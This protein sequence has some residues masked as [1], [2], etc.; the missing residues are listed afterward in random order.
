MAGD[1][2]DSG[3]LIGLGVP[4]T[5][6]L[7]SKSGAYI[8]SPDNHEQNMPP[9]EEIVTESTSILIIGFD[10]STKKNESVNR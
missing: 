2:P 7:W 6:V 10:K 1:C 4:P 3:L 9:D 8:L 5:A